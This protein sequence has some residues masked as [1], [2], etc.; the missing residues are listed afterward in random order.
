[1]R[2]LAF[3][4]DLG[5]R[6]RQQTWADPGHL[7]GPLLPGGPQELARVAP[8]GHVQPKSSSFVGTLFKS[9]VGQNQERRG[10]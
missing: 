2:S 4:G 1:M 7:Q 5:H 3:P 9:P 10:G 8:G 6:T